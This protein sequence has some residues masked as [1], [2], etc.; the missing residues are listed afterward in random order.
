MKNVN[1]KNLRRFDL[2][3]IRTNPGYQTNKNIVNTGAFSAQAGY[4]MSGDVSAVQRS[5]LP[6]IMTGLGSVGNA[7]MNFAS[8]YTSQSAATAANLATIGKTAE[9]ATK[10]ANAAG[11]SLDAYAASQAGSSAVKAGMSTAGKLVSVAGALYGTGSMIKDFTN[12]KNRLGAQDFQGMTATS[13]Q[14]KNGINYKTY[15]GFD[16]NQVRDYTRAQNKADT[17]SAT[18]NGMSAGASAGSLGGWLGTAIG[19]VAGGITG[20]VGGLFGSKDRMKKVEDTI[21]NTTAMQYGYNT[22]SEYEA[23]SVGLRN[24]FN[25]THGGAT[26]AGADGGKRPG[27]SLSGGKYGLIQTPSGPAY[28]EI[29]G[30]ASPDEGQIDM[31]TGE[32]NYNGSKDMNVR[33][34]R[35]DVIP[36]GIT[37]YANGGAFDNNVGIPG[38]ETDINGLSFADNARPLFKANEQLKDAA[39]AVDMEL[40]ENEAHKTRNEATKRYMENRLNQKKEQIQ[41]QYQQNAQGIADIV[42]R[43]TAMTN[44]GYY[45]GG[46]SPRFWD[47][48]TLKM[49]DSIYRTYLSPDNNNWRNGLK[50]EYKLNRDFTDWP[51]EDSYK[52]HFLPKNMTPLQKFMANPYTPEESENATT[53]ESD[54]NSG[55]NPW[56]ATY[57]GLNPIYGGLNALA[58]NVANTRAANEHQPYAQNSFVPNST[59]Q[60]A[61]N[62]L[63]SLGYNPSEQDKQ[64]VSAGRQNIYNINSA[65]SLSAGQREALKQAGLISLAQSRNALYDKKQEVDN[66]YKSAYASALMNYGQDEASRAQQ[67]NAYQQEAYRQAV[68][69]K[70]KLQAQARKDWYTTGMQNLQDWTK[71]LNTQ[72][73]LDLWDRQVAVDE[74][75]A[76]IKRPT[77]TTKAKAKASKKSGKTVPTKDFNAMMMNPKIYG[78]P[79][80]NPSDGKARF[81]GI[82]IGSPSQIVPKSKL[83]L[84]GMPKSDD[85]ILTAAYQMIPGMNRPGMRNSAL[86]YFRKYGNFNGFGL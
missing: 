81:V 64:L 14:S 35:A 4:D 44:G 45:C 46:K 73:M 26:S 41:Q 65:G 31:V 22:Q 77:T 58:Y 83:D 86:R 84:S 37:G 18:L 80:Y 21:T 54:T 40:Q 51:I 71:Y 13:T 24:R 47:G 9:E 28:G 42:N 72:G 7:A 6:T 78:G 15:D 20:L 17:W 43:Q 19:A 62:V 25:Q 34:R 67:A 49:P 63:G 36:V 50:Q 66:G 8:N 10:L 69:A 55:I 68:G 74:A 70:Q 75:K 61:L 60:A 16:E 23:G 76:G 82:N 32:T 29:E 1:Y 3:T 59:A 56:K 5:V 11:Q 52:T 38:H 85:E 48:K 79:Y 57:A 33:D 53:P 27:E 2:G 12:F 39:A 30:L